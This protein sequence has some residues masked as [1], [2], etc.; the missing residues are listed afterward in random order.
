MCFICLEKQ[1]KYVYIQ[2]LRSYIEV[3][4]Y[5]VSLQLAFKSSKATYNRHLLIEHTHLPYDYIIYLMT[6]QL[7]AGSFLPV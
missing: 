1:I 4:V 7:I 5:Y 6:S 3:T 2:G